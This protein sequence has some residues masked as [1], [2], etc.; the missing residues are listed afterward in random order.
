MTNKLKLLTKIGI[1][2]FTI[3][4]LLTNCQ[5]ENDLIENLEEDNTFP[6]SVSKLSFKE[7]SKNS[8]LLGQIENINN[9]VDQ[10]TTVSA[11]K[12]SNNK[13]IFLSKYNFYVDTDEGNYLESLDA[14]Y[15]SYTFPIY[16][17]NPNENNLVENL[18]FSFNKDKNLYDTFVITYNLTNQERALL[19]SNNSVNLEDK[20]SIEYLKDFDTGTVLN[21]LMVYVDLVSGDVSCWQEVWGSS[22]GT[23]WD[24]IVGWNEV[25]CPWSGG[26]GGGGSGDFDNGGSTSTSGSETNSYGVPQEYEE[27]TTYTNPGGSSGGNSIGG[28]TGPVTS[29]Y[30]LPIEEQRKKTLHKIQLTPEESTDLISFD[31]ETQNAIYEFLEQASIESDI[32][33]EAPSYPEE[34]VKWAKSQIELETLQRKRTITL[35]PV[36][37]KINNRDDQKYTHFGT[38]GVYSFYKMEDGSIVLSSPSPLTLNSDNQL[39]AK[40]TSETSNEHYW[41]IKPEGINIWSNYLIKTNYTNLAHELEITAKLALLELGKAIGTYV[42]PIEDAKILITGTDFDGEQVSRLQTAG[43]MIVGIIPG[44]KLLKP[45]SKGTGKVWKV[46]IKNGDK[47]FTRT[48]RELS[49]ETIQHFD[50]YVEGAKDLLEEALRKGDILDDEIIIEVGQEI[51]D[52]SDK[53]RRKLTWP[54]VKALF[55]RGQDFNKKGLD[56]YGYNSVEIVLADGKRLDTYIHGQKIISR[57]ATDIDNIKESTWR[58]Y[59]NELVTKYKAGKLTNSS[60]L[61]N[62][63]NLSGKYYL[64]IP[65]SNQNARNLE[66]FKQIASEYGTLNQLE[67]IIIT[68]LTE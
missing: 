18:L 5:K 62:Q 1:L 32:L 47:V 21:S 7:V 57:K 54:E 15:H 36:N 3:S 42:L 23:G 10:N 2:L 50:N 14:T 63:V 67:G 59:C 65:A 68:F 48:I 19:S 38:D 11:S 27:N 4:L 58:N 43:F 46:V 52:L 53:K 41:Y 45:L 13:I 66:R 61:N 22:Q 33:E 39:V 8:K 49:E 35:E 25:T 31:I 37:G 16:R 9:N 6:Y 12:N 28:K 40:F 55:K 34:V 24:D 20:V 29:P 60:K 51:K 56:E 44:G 30:V 26:G 64:E 17:T